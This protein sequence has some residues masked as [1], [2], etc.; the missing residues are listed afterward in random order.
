[1][2]EV[3]LPRL[4]CYRCVYSWTPAKS[5]VRMCPRCKSR[6]WDVPRVRP[7]RLG[8]GQGIDDILLP[9]R[10]EILRAARKLGANRV[11]V[12]GSVRRREADLASDVDLLV[13]WKPGAS[14][15]AALRLEVALSKLLG[16]RVSV[17]Q[18]ADLPW[19]FRPQVLAEAVA[20]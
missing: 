10:A 11:L 7:V 1:M 14:P 17:A 3:R 16:R 19:S 15:L 6:L 9:Q 5:P 20:W 4:R 8:Q 2:K 13:H 12:Y 18:E